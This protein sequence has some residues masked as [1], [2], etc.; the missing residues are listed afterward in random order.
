M[1]EPS[2]EPGKTWPRTAI[3]GMWGERIIC[4]HSWGGPINTDTCELYM[5]L[6][7]VSCQCL[8]SSGGHRPGSRHSVHSE[9]QMRR[10]WG[11]KV[12]WVQEFKAYDSHTRW[13]M[14]TVSC[15]ERG[16]LMIGYCFFDFSDEYTWHA[17]LDF[18]SHALVFPMACPFCCS[19]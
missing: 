12:S 18:D 4:W 2:E 7:P 6:S 17:G 16:L 10:S 5:G 9:S 11:R 8:S 1:P 14:C 3:W 15:C 13:P 19:L